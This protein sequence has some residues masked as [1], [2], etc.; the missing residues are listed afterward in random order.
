MLGNIFVVH[1]KP[2]TRIFQQSL[3]GI[4]TYPNSN[5][6]FQRY[7][8]YRDCLDWWWEAETQKA[9]YLVMHLQE[10]H[11]LFCQLYP[12]EGD[13]SIISFSKFCSLCPKNVLI[14]GDIPQY[15]C[16]WMIHE[17]FFLKPKA[18]GNSHG[19]Y[20]SHISFGKYHPTYLLGA[21]IYLYIYLQL[22]YTHI[23]ML[24]T[25]WYQ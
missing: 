19:R 1:I 3:T 21:Y 2:K 13:Y 25:T 5:D 6:L 16:K 8:W 10:A 23:Y 24:S 20:E 18:L 9:L 12:T 11:Q 15:Q 22:L 14:T 17:N 4:Y 7:A